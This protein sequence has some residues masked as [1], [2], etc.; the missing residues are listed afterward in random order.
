MSLV[1]RGHG[2]A[3]TLASAIR[4]AIWSIDKN[5]PVM[6]V[7]TMG[8]LLDASAAE[9]RFALVL[10]EGFALAALV[11]AAA[12]IYGVLAGSVT[13]RT[14]EIGVRAALGASRARILTLVVRDGMTLAGLGVAVGLAGAL[15]ATRA[16]VAMLFGISRLDPATYAG[17]IAVLAG[18]SAFSCAIPAWRAARVDPA[19]TLRSE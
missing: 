19:I 11:L 9:R 15:V 10:F 4:D 18:V 16:L 8:A 1:V 7:A 17:V 13:E 6:R 14:R 5:Q 3:A 12:G 2:D